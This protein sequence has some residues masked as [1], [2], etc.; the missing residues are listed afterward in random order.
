MP[1][2]AIVE[3]AYKLSSSDATINNRFDTYNTQAGVSLMG[4]QKL[5]N[6]LFM[7]KFTLDAFV[8]IAE[9]SLRPR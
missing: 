6:I 1:R 5:G 4:K 8:Y 9:K 7:P 2:W 3:S